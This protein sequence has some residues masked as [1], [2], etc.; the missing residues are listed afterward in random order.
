MA[1]AVPASACTAV[2]GVAGKIAIIDWTLL[3]GGAN[4][5]GSGTRAT[6]AF[7]AGATGIIFVAPATG[8][9]NLG[10]I[11]AIASVQVTNADGAT[12]KAG[13]PASATIAMGVGT[14]NSVRWLVGEDDAAVGLSGALRDM[15]NPRCFGNPGK[16]S[17]TF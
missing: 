4:E 14:D 9:L 5:C 13:L 1:L 11:A 3:P 10:S 2:S 16:V 17:D 7:N 6:N 8:L 15:W 12:I